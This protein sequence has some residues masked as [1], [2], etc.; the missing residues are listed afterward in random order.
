MSVY[1]RFKKQLDGL[2]QLV[3]LLETTPIARRQNMIDVGMKEDPTYTQT[4]LQY[5]LNFTDVLQL[6]DLELAELLS[7]VPPRFIALAIHAAGEDVKNRFLSKCPNKSVGEVK[8]LL[9]TSGVSMSQ[10]GSAQMKLIETTRRL[11]KK[12]LVKTK[13]IPT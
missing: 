11:E 5:V 7:E 3:E 6:P 2:R 10:I 12:G 13:R 8:E 9:G 1:S 4:A